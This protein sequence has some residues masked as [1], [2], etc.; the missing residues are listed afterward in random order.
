MSDSKLLQQ[1]LAG[2]TK[3]EYVH[4]FRLL[5]NKQMSL[6]QRITSILG[7]LISAGYLVAPI[8]F[9]PDLAPYGLVDDGGIVAVALAIAAGIRKF[10]SYRT[11]GAVKKISEENAELSAETDAARQALFAIYKHNYKRT[12]TDEQLDDFIARMVKMS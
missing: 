11:A 9:L 12:P 4:M 1:N 10:N 3:S 7:Y 5:Q 2:L 6:P 8:D